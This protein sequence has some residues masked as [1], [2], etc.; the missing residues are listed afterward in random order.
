MSRGY[1][2]FL[3]AIADNRDWAQEERLGRSMY[4]APVDRAV[5][6]LWADPVAWCSAC[7]WRVLNA[8]ATFPS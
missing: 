2:A 1:A 3:K 7:R 5:D 8:P 4:D 6:M